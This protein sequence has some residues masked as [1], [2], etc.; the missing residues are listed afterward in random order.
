[1]ADST[2]TESGP[3]NDEMPERIHTSDWATTELG[4]VVTWPASL[5]TIVDV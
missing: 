1:M 3:A 4:P 5:V 2:R